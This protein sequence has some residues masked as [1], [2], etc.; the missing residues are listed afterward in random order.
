MDDDMTYE[1]DGKPEMSLGTVE[2][3]EFVDCE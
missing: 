1:E 3:N 2:D